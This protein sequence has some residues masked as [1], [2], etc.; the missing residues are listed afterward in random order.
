LCG[1]LEHQD[2]REHIIDQGGVDLNAHT[3]FGQSDQ[4]LHAQYTFQVPEEKLDLPAQ[5]INLSDQAHRIELV[6]QDAGQ[7]K[8][9]ATFDDFAHETHVMFHFGIGRPGA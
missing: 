8:T 1:S 4:V 9:P 2:M 7:V 5:G 6:I 3:V